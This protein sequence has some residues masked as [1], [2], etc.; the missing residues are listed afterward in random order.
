MRNTLDPGRAATERQTLP[1]QQN[2]IDDSFH[3]GEPLRSAETIRQIAE[4]GAE[5]SWWDRW[6]LALAAGGCWSFLLA[7]LIARH[8]LDA[9]ETVVVALFAGAYLAGGTFAAIAAV[10]DL[11]RGRVNVDL[12]MVVAALGAA[13]VGHWSEG[14][15][16]LGLFSLSTALEQYALGRTHR[17]VRSLMDLAP[18][19][20]TL[21]DPAAPG[22]ERVV[23]VAELVVGNRVLI[24]P[25]ERIAVDGEVAVGESAVD[26]AAITGESV[27]VDKRSGDSVFAGTMNTTGALEVIV[28]RPR[29][30]SALARIVQIVDNA[31]EQKSETQRFTDRFEGRYTVAVI[32]GSVLAFL[33]FWQLTD[34]TRADAFYRAITLLVV[35]SPCA[36]VISTPASTL[37]GLANAARNGV[38]FKGSGYL[39]DLGQVRTMVFDKTG[40][41]TLGKPVVTDVV[42]CDDAWTNDRLLATAASAERLSEHPLAMAITDG[43]LRRG[44]PL[45]DASAFRAVLGKGLVAEVNGDQVAVGTS[46]LMADLGI[47]AAR[48]NRAADRLRA[49]GKTAMLV[50][51]GSAVRGVIAVAD[52]LRP[53][54]GQVIAELKTLG[55]ERTVMLTGDHGVVARAIGDQVGIDEIESELLPEE[56]LAT[57][58]RLL[59]RGSVAMVGDGVND[60]PAL[61]S[62]TVGVAM[63][64]AGSDVA[65]ET[66]DVVLVADDLTKLPYAVALSQRTRRTIVQNLAFALLVIVVLVTA[67]LTIGIPLPLGVVGHEGSTI[68]VVLN[69]L[70][71]LRTPS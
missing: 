36:L 20:A 31:R 39:E 54:A 14:A 27:P 37:S 43:A 66:A 13:I 35:A 38:L 67:S 17:A 70:R 40:T 65:L 53:S 51:V 5:E 4:Q 1:E 33:L 63:G 6:R 21:L 68:V 12:L 71:L 46:E 3:A 23:P 45:G 9:P 48:A 59:A 69:G 24:R 18:E 60:A 25:G 34:M 30:E 11:L 2:P 57:V 61:A 29:Q 10:T 16:L 26:Q 58:E 41:L 42:S 47:D 8:L 7:A 56:K 32:V 44:L 62:V 49:E 64:G 55:V 19:E 28:T 15:V 22:G 52:T 50:A